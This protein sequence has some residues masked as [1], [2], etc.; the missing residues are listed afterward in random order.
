MKLIVDVN[1]RSLAKRVIKNLKLLNINIDSENLVAG[2][3]Y[4]PGVEGLQSYLVERKTTTDLVLSVKTRRLWD[5]LLAIKSVENVTPL[6][7]IEGSLSQ[8]E[9]FSGWR[10]P[11]VA[12]ILATIA[13][14]WKVQILPSSSERWTAYIL[15]SLCRRAQIKEEPRPRPL[16][17]SASLELTP[18][19]AARYVLE[20]FPMIGPSKAEEILKYFGNLYEAITHVDWWNRLPGIGKKTISKIKEILYAKWE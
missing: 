1:E 10:P 5:Q 16:R 11:A 20:G 17:V 19:E 7:I 12:A 6:L 3:Y 13:F 4:I 18:Q 15:Y 2:D 8:I 14:D 9:K